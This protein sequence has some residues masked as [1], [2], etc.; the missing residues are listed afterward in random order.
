M[1]FRTKTPQWFLV[2]YAVLITVLGIFSLID[3][4]KGTECV[5][6]IYYTMIFVLFS[7]AMVVYFMSKG[8]EIKSWL[9]PLC[10]LVLAFV[11]ISLQTFFD[12]VWSYAGAR[13]IQYLKTI[14]FW[15]FIFFI[16]LLYLHPHV[17]RKFKRKRK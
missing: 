5:V 10:F 6:G 8:Y 15:V 17:K 12:R 3:L 7:I 2:L 1:Q 9:M 14:L 16:D 11:G 4:I 13:A